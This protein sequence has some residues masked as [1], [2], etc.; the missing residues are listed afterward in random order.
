MKKSLL[1]AMMVLSAVTS[2]HANDELSFE[3]R[4]QSAINPYQ[5]ALIPF[6]GDSIVTSTINNN[7]I[8][9]D[10][11]STRSKSACAPFVIG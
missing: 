9:T 10:V 4:K 2:S 1:F 8:H 6:A 3:I 7:L 11:K 5:I